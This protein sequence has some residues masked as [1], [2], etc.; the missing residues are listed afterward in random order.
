MQGSERANHPSQ[1]P[2]MNVKHHM[3][4][5]RE[6]LAFPELEM[7]IKVKGVLES[8]CKVDLAACATQLPNSF[9]GM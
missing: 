3:H 1:S 9:E 7:N 8:A 2:R 5:K 6:I 4:L